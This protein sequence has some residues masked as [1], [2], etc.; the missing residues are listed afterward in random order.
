MLTLHKDRELVIPGWQGQPNGLKQ[1]LWERG[2]IDV[3]ALEKYTLDERK[4]PITGK[5]N[6]QSSL[7]HILANCKDFK[8]EE[9]A[10][11]YLG[12][13]LGVTVKLTPKRVEYSWTHSKSFYRF[14]R[15]HKREAERI[16]S[17]LFETAPALKEY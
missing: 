15:C 17:S 4:D 1:V 16:S 8:D 6:L 3:S 7:R 9:T 10:L 12:T 11:E 13:Q 14:S 5:V 2:L